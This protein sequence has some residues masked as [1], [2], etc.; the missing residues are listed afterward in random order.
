M[1]GKPVLA[2]VH[3]R[4]LFADR[5]PD[6]L[7]EPSAP[8]LSRLFSIAA[9]LPTWWRDVCRSGNEWFRGNYVDLFPTRMPRPLYAT[10]P[11]PSCNDMNASH[12]S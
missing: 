3:R 8:A 1:G 9:L 11:L 4:D 5:T 2:G 10:S 6:G 12:A 7:F